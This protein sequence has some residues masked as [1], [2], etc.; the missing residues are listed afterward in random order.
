[1]AGLQIDPVAGKQFIDDYRIHTGHL[2]GPI[3]AEVYDMIQML[4]AAMAKGGYNGEAIAKQLA[5]LKGVPS[6]FGSTI[7]MDPEHYSV[8]ST[9]TLWI[10]KNNKLVKA[11]P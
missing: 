5:V 1:M 3:A 10:F 8:P 11:M 7:T 6:V 9:D 4:A 2:P